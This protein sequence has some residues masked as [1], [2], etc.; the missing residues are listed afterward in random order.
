MYIIGLAVSL[1]RKLSEK[2]RDPNAP[3]SSVA[4][5]G[6]EEDEGGIPPDVVPARES[7]LGALQMQAVEW[8]KEGMLADLLAFVGC[9]E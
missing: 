8:G 2:A 1:L 4:G 7:V 3:A 6:T 9:A 5:A